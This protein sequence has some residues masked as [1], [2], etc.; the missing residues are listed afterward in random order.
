MIWVNDRSEAA[1]SAQASRLRAIGRWWRIDGVRAN[2]TPSYFRAWLANPLKFGAVAPSGPAL[3][4]LITSEISAD[5]GPVLELGPGKGVFTRALLDRGVPEDSLILVERRA[6]FANLLNE[7]FPQARVV[8][9][10]ADELHR[11][12]P[13]FADHPAGAVI[14]GLPLLSMPLEKVRGILSGAFAQMRRDGAFYQFTYMPRCPVAHHTLD[15][16]GLRAERIGG[17]LF[18]LPPA[19]V[20]RITRA[21]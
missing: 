19:A 8:S 5:D 13:V 20:Y 10:D 15:R 14:S 6:D 12:A 21:A 2:C 17:A 1:S 18:N 4:S 16:M 9:M 7:R 11:L 3:A